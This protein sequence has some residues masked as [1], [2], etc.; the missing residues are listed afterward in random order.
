MN[1]LIE[2]NPKVC[3]GRP[4]IRGTRIPVAVLL[5]QLRE[6]EAWDSIM[7][8]FPELK[9]EHIQAAL[10]FARSSVEHTEIHAI[11]A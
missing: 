6:G 11:G 3:N 9:R 1:A 2:I 4:V 10:D 5:D 8:G 7:K